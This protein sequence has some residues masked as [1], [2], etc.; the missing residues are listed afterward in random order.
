MSD[1]GSEGS[2]AHVSERFLARC[3]RTHAQALGFAQPQEGGGIALSVVLMKMMRRARK[4]D[5]AKILLKGQH[6]HFYDEIK[7]IEI[8]TVP[9]LLC[10]NNTLN[11]GTVAPQSVK[12]RT[13]VQC[14][15]L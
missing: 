1:D 4:E 11:P 12:R 2:L 7:Y 9:V 14:R 6:S 8:M 5:E 3:S 10:E 13:S 15:Q